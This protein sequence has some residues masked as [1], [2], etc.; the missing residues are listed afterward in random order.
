[1]TS[2]RRWASI[3]VVMV[4]AGAP[5]RAT[6]QTA[7]ARQAAEAAMKQ[8]DEAFCQ[9]A[10]DHDESRFR[11]LVADEATFGG[12]SPDQTRGVDAIVKSWAPFLQAGG[13][14]LTWKPTHA[15]V[16]AGAEIGYTVGTWE[17][18]SKRPDGGEAVARGQYMTVWAKQS[19]GRWKA[20][21]DTGGEDPRK[22]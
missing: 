9:A 20:V 7:A 1:M 3:A 18:R 6:A 13:P 22:P 12:G 16:L 4:V 21:F 5:A 10:I 15:E 14:S 2:M 11:A 17:R 8:A 19:D